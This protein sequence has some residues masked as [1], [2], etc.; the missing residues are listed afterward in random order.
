LLSLCLVAQKSPG[1]L[2]DHWLSRFRK[3]E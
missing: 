1:K 2:M 3:E